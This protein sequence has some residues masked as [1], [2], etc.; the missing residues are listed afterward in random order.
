VSW[1][2]LREG[3]VEKNG[4]NRWPDDP[5]FKGSFICGGEKKKKKEYEGDEAKSEAL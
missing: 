1:C 2:C 3:D 4:G 5:K